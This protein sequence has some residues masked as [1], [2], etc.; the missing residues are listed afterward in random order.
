[1]N[2]A[3]RVVPL[4]VCL[5]SLP[6]V[7]GEAG[8]VKY[9]DKFHLI[10]P[11]TV[12]ANE[13]KLKVVPGEDPEHSRALELSADFAKPGTHTCLS[14]TFVPGTI[15]AKRYG[16]VRFFIKSPTGT[17]VSIGMAGSY[18]RPD[19]RL[20]SF[21]GGAVVGNGQWKE[22]K[23]PFSQFKRAGA[24]FWKDGVQVVVQGGDSMEEFEV[25][26]LNSIYFSMGVETRGNSTIAKV[27]L[28]GLS[29]VEHSEA[30]RA[31]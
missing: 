29:L 2:K 24:K 9:L 4:A 14:K 25:G 10:D 27:L 23:I 28:E 22:V 3:L 1:M 16:G 17:R 20:T 19:G 26:Q 31:Q 11:K 30:S 8:P 13:I 18:K 12:K 5:L 7:A 15:N 6:S 21:H